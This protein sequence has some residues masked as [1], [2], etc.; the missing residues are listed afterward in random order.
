MITKLTIFT[1]RKV[2]VL[3]AWQATI[4]ACAV[5]LLLFPLQLASAQTQV[6]VSTP[7]GD[8]VLELY[9]KE[10]PVT[11]ENFLNYVNSG[12]Y[13]GTF[14]HRTEPDFV[15]QG[16]WRTY[17]PETNT[18]P[19]I[20]IDPEIVNEPG[21]S[22]VRGTIAMAKVANNPDS[23]T[24]QWFINLSDNINLDT[25]NGGFTVF[26]RVIGEGM[27]IVDTIANLPAQQILSGTN[28]PVPLIDYDGGSLQAS[29]FVT[30]EMSVVKETAPNVYDPV[31]GLLNLK[32]DAGSLGIAAASFT[33]ESQEP[34][35]VI[36][37]LSESLMLLPEAGPGFATLDVVTGQLVIPELIVDGNV[38]YR[39]VVFMLTDIGQLLFTLLSNE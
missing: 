14:I 11:V 9:D 12:R 19:E 13:N 23:A 16:G 34:E 4:K 38:A 31:S 36:K 27:A 21:I 37:G 7:L 30:V 5:L 6:R 32:I 22:N 1:V 25:N 39:N 20:N 18:F 15:I 8:F 2:A 28:F 26:G 35:V 24:S 17:Q 29:N 10:T 33:I 3:H